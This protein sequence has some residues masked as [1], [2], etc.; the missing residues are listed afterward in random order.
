MQLAQSHIVICHDYTKTYP[1][2]F[3]QCPAGLQLPE[4]NREHLAWLSDRATGKA[5]PDFRPICQSYCA[6]GPT[7]VTAGVWAH[8]Y[9]MTASSVALLNM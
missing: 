8:Y 2:R 4:V 7:R 3:C 6:K 5:H 1:Y 9:L